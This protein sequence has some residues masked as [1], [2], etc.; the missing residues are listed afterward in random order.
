MHLFF[1]SVSFTMQCKSLTSAMIVFNSSQVGFLKS[2]ET[3]N[4]RSTMLLLFQNECVS[5]SVNG[6]PAKSPQQIWHFSPAQISTVVLHHEKHVKGS[7][8]Y[9]FPQN[10]V[11]LFNKNVEFLTHNKCVHFKRQIIILI[12]FE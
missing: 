7:F 1:A 10:I 5:E 11:H 12:F 3:M 9:S 6:V 4:F 2:Y 8:N